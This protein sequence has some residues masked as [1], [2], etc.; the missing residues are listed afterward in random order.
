MTD[1]DLAF[2]VVA[3]GHD[4]RNVMLKDIMTRRPVSINPDTS[5]ADALAKMAE[6][7]FRHLPVVD[8]G[9]VVGVLDITRC[10]YE[11]MERLQKAYASSRV[12]QQAFE[13]VEKLWATYGF[14]L[15]FF[16]F[17]SCCVNSVRSQMISFSEILRE[18]MTCP[19]VGQVLES[20]G[21]R[22][23]VVDI[24][25]NVIDVRLLLTIS[26]DSYPLLARPL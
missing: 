16:I 26:L 5:Y 13:S 4:P 21:A 17:C 12:L 11:G 23:A 14:P 15:S 7:R 20:S 3:D 24:R 19:T 22:L 1:K 9:V 8:E 2:R 18:R 6:G 25:S 10:L